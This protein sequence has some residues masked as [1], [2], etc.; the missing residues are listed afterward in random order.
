MFY[1]GFFYDQVPKVA[2]VRSRGFFINLQSVDCGEPIAMHGNF[3][4]II[5]F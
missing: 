3:Y 2:I 4:N 1:Q 5:L